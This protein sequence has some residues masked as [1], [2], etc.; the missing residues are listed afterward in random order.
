MKELLK[1]FDAA[2]AQCFKQEDREK[3]LAVIEAGFGD[4]QEFNLDVR[5]AF[6]QR[7]RDQSLRSLRN[8]FRSAQALSVSYKD[9]RRSCPGEML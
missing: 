6:A 7:L 8:L 1:H 5:N 3:L 9:V 4:F 2:E